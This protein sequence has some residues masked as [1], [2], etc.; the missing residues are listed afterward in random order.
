MSHFITLTLWLVQALAGAA[1]TSTLVRI[2]QVLPGRP[3]G[4]LFFVLLEKGLSGLWE[5]LEKLWKEVKEK[6]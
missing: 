5:E 3:I 2:A 6:K 1:K 4:D